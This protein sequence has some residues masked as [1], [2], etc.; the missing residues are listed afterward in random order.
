MEMAPNAIASTSQSHGDRRKPDRVS[1]APAVS[2]VDSSRASPDEG[3]ADSRRPT[4]FDASAGVAEAAEAVRSSS[5]GAGTGVG[6]GA[7]K[8][9]ENEGAPPAALEAC[10]ALRAF[11]AVPAV[12]ADCA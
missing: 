9:V 8:F 5:F 11:G 10:G 2:R 12:A 1:G 6:E 4:S 3:P 7:G